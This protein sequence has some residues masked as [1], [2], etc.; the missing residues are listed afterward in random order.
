MNRTIG[1]RPGTRIA[2]IEVHEFGYTVEGLGVDSSGNRCVMKSA[3]SRLSAFAVRIE[4]Q[5]GHRGEYCS[6]HSG[7]N[8]AMVGQVKAAAG[9]LLDEDAE[10]REAIYNKLKRVHRH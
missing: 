2:R 1:S 4:T 3:S 7:K 9:H 8:G 6:V 5:D 10:E